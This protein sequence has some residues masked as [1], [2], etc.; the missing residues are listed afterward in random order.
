MTTPAWL[1][2]MDEALRESASG[3]PDLAHRLALL[4]TRLLQ[5]TVRVLVVGG[6]KEGKSQLVNAVINAPIC[7]VADHVTT[8]LPTVLR[9]AESPQAELL[10]P[11][12][13]VGAGPSIG[14]G[15]LAERVPIPVDRF[16]AEITAL[17]RTSRDRELIRAEVGLPRTLLAQGLVLVDCPSIDHISPAQA[18]EA[19]A[20]VDVVLL[21][22]DAI[23][24]FTST[25]L[26]FLQEAAR[27][28]A[29]V[30][31]V[32]TKTD[33]S[34]QWRR[35]VRSDGETLAKL[36]HGIGVFAASSTLRLQAARANNQ[37][38]N[39]ESGFPQLL[40]YLQRL[41]AQRTDGIARQAA[42]R[43][44]IAV[45]DQILPVER[46]RLMLQAPPD[47]APSMRQLQVAQRRAEQLRRRSNRWQ[48]ELSDGMAD[49][50]SDVDHDLRERTRGILRESER[51][52]N[53]TDPIKVWD[54]FA[55][56]LVENLS[57]AVLS[58]F[59]W[60]AART[61]WLA[62]HVAGFFTDASGGE[63]PELDLALPS[64]VED[65]LADLEKPEIEPIRVGHKIV[66]GLRGSYSGVLMFGMLS[67]F[68]GLPMINPISLGAGAFLGTRSIREDRDA[69]LKRRQATAKTAAQR[70]VEEVVFQSSKY[71]RDA[72]RQVQRTLR[73]HFTTLAEELQ[74][75]AA[76]SITT[77]TRAAQ[78]EAVERDR[79]DRGIAG[80][81]ERLMLLR[82]RAE[83]L[84][85][86]PVIAA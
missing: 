41:V 33:L 55:E 76:E 6:A 53:R 80:Q 5:P 13:P 3:R 82:R 8:V 72:L 69:Q 11:R 16:A 57:E 50:I 73:N 2:V 4:R 20:E 37:Q 52:F 60:A 35:V 34:G 38:L 36:A 18:R 74:D 28:C 58:N 23:H 40:T 59:S 83:S 44:V 32:R 21:V 70:H 63:L 62:R 67:G 65:R 75:A 81:M 48:H 51:T 39:Q 25:E 10:K 66:T 77:A 85:S 9:Y 71:S 15:E 29:N 24:A 56:W 78:R 47:E 42:A 61:R 27:S 68:T 30:A 43:A 49:L 46:A 7:P 14:A 19:F 31:S 79:H 26:D 17:A 86:T 84:L 22:S 45:I 54:S 12:D 64:D 1:D